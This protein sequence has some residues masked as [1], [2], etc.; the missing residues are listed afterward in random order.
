MRPGPGQ[1]LILCFP[2]P[3]IWPHLFPRDSSNMLSRFLPQ[4]LHMLFPLLGMAFPEIFLGCSLL[5]LRS[6]LQ[7]SVSE[8]FLTAPHGTVFPA[9]PDSLSQVTQLIVLLGAIGICCNSINF[10][11]SSHVSCNCDHFCVQELQEDSLSQ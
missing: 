8:A 10:Q 1:T 4:G 2:F 11:G 9:P 6:Q 5:T 3:I 7:F